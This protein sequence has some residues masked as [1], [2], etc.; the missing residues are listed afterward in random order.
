MKTTKLLFIFCTVFSKLILAQCDFGTGSVLGNPAPFSNGSAA[1]TVNGNDVTVVSNTNMPGGIYNFNNFTVNAGVVI[2]VVSGLGPLEIRCIGT[3]T[4]NGTIRADGG[5]GGNGTQGTF[6]GGIGGAGGTGGGGWGANGGL[7][8]SVGLGVNGNPGLNFGTSLGSGSGGIGNSSSAPWS[9]GGGGGA[10]Y[11]SNGT[12]GNTTDGGTGGTAGNAYGDVNLTTTMTYL[13]YTTSLLGGSGG[14]GGGNRGNISRAAGGGGGGGGGAIQ[15]V[16][17][18]IV[19]GVAGLVSVKGGDGGTSTNNGGAYGGSGGGGSGGTINLKSSNIVGFTAGINSNILGGTGGISS[20]TNGGPA[21]GGNGSQGRIL[22]EPCAPPSNTITTGTITGSPFCAGATFNV[23]FTST[24]VFT[25]GNVYTAQ[26]SDASGSFASPINIGTLNS[27]TN[28]GSIS[29]TIPGGTATGGGYLIRVIA[30]NP[31]TTGSNSTAFT[32]NAT[33]PPSVSISTSQTTI[34]AGTSVS[35]TAT[36]TNGGTT[37]TY[38]WTVNGSPV[39]TN[40]ASFTSNTLTNNA[41]VQVTMTS[42]LACVSPLSAVSNTV[43]MVVNGTVAP[44]VSISTSQTT[45]C[46]GTSVTFTATPTNGGTTP[47]YAWTVNGSPVGTNSASFTSNTLTNNA[48]VQVTMTSNLACVSPSNAASNTISITVNPIVTPIVG[49][50]A[51]PGSTTCVSVPV[52]LTA[53]PTNGGTAPSYSWT[54]NGNP[55]GTNSPTFVYTPSPS[56]VIIQVTMT[57][58]ATCLSTSTSTSIGISVTGTSTPTVSISSNPSNIICDGTPVTFSATPTSGG[59][60]PVYNWTVNGNPVGSN[61]P[62]FSNSSLNDG[63]IVQVLLTSNANC[64]SP[65]TASSNTIIMEV[66]SGSDLAVTL[67]T[68]SSTFCSG[69]TVLFDATTTPSNLSNATYTWSINGTPQVGNSPAFSS[70]TLS[71][72]DIVTVSIASTDNCLN[73]SSATSNA[74]TM[75][76]SD[77]NYTALLNSDNTGAVCNGTLVNF[78]VASNPIPSNANYQWFVQGIAVSGNN[79]PT[80]SQVISPTSNSVYVVITVADVCFSPSV[81]TTDTVQVQIQSQ[82]ITSVITV[83]PN[84]TPCPATPLSF[85]STNLPVTGA[86]IYQWN[87]NGNPIAGAN[88]ESLNVDVYNSGDIFS[89]TVSS[90]DNCLAGPTNSNSITINNTANVVAQVSATAS[91][92]SICQGAP[93]TITATG[94]NGGNNPLYGL[95]VN[96][97]QIDSNS[98]GVF[99][100]NALTVGAQLMITLT[101]S[102]PCIIVNPVSVNIP[103]TV[104][105]GLQITSSSVPADCNGKPTGS[106]TALAVG[107]VAPYTYVWSNVTPG[108]TSTISNLLAGDYSVTITDSQG[109]ANT[110]NVTVTEPTAITLGSSTIIAQS[111]V[112]NPSGSITVNVTGGTPPYSYLWNTTPIQT[113]N[114]ATG[115]TSGEYILTVT[116]NNGCSQIFTFN[117]PNTVSTDELGF[118][119]ISIYPTPFSN[120]IFV[121]ANDLNNG[122]SSFLIFDVAGKKILSEKNVFVKNGLYEIN[123]SMLSVG[124]YFLEI[125]Q[126]HKNIT[127][128]IIKF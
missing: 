108:N 52:T 55:V 119:D 13:G 118:S 51:T 120:S 127:K 41:T 56:T 98:S 2:T 104:T 67:N 65:S 115:L 39:G 114:S 96:G 58:N 95:F 12:A 32:I 99:T 31:A 117:V 1:V 89:L 60:S 10:G 4:I 63:D 121:K 85:G 92:S 16:A 36:P 78:S 111:T 123:T 40:S 45:I 11:F 80:L 29:V 17:N 73:N 5:N 69:Q 50:S 26:L 15:I 126:S 113:T 81:V 102:E 110:S 122:I 70:N 18:S 22:V 128:K 62:T 86:F 23:P 74:I 48:T 84:D 124:V 125:T 79:S 112:N 100:T 57:S 47:T 28:T 46:A 35:F 103:I 83:S 77:V 7:G 37:P 25:S 116:D 33:A 38:A 72:N 49:I 71:N 76:N 54:A 6:S 82:Q 30:N 20:G 88:S 97:T 101:S 61:S 90:N 8:G 87:V 64:I 93:I 105:P 66:N 14:G 68:T 91:S 34:C 42:N 3:S 94:V 59:T 43:T 106:A 44:S 53:S 19:F 107:G 24:G 109:C 21:N 75:T 9:A 27:T